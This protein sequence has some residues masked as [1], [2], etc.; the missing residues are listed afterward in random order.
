LANE[1]DAEQDAEDSPKRYPQI[2]DTKAIRA[3]CYE[4]KDENRHSG[5]KHGE[6]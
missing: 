3:D 1:C 6:C 4:E 5:Q 2:T